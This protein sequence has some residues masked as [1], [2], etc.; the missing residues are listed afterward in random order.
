MVSYLIWLTCIHA[1]T[2]QASQACQNALRA[3]SVMS[4]VDSVD[5]TAELKLQRYATS[6]VPTEAA[7]ASALAYE[8]AVK[9]RITAK[10][11][12]DPVSDT[13]SVT[14]SLQTCTVS[15]SWRF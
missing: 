4:G 5:K 6:L 3:A 14:G 8:V 7:A 15:L 1:A 13:I 11:N 9:H 12:G 2:G 10:F